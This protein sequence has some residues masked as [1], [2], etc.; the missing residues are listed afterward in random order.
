MTLMMTELGP[1]VYWLRIVSQEG[2][3]K[4]TR[5]WESAKRL[6][7]VEEWL[8]SN[9][10]E[11]KEVELPLHCT[12]YYDK[13]GQDF[14]YS[15][16]VH[17][18]YAATRTLMT[19]ALW[20]GKEGAAM[21][22]ELTAKERELMKHREGLTPHVS[23]AVSKGHSARELGRMLTR[24]R[25]ASEPPGRDSETQSTLH[26]SRRGDGWKVR[27]P[28]QILT[29][30]LERHEMNSERPCRQANRGT[31]MEERLQE[32]PVELWTRHPNDVG[33]VLAATPVSI[34]IKEGIP[35]PRVAQYP[36]RKEAIEGIAPVIASLRDQGVIIPTKSQCNT[37]IL[38]VE[39]P[40][41]NKWRFVQDLRAVNK[42]VK[43]SFPVVP[44]PP[45]P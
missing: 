24:L 38:P 12:V 43:A 36:L 31:R 39:K 32:V 20:I 9:D 29:C 18:E 21:E 1:V 44:H 2:R 3:D 17:E 33:R 8:R 7:D 27:L 15:D 5:D 35:L 10:I 45:P 40:G 23:M 30:M 22:V 14:D 4:L 16:R 37:P 25:C 11:L 28:D 13:T 42:C 26:A 6:R 41:G 19:T 34:Q